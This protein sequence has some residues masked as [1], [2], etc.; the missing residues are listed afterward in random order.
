VQNQAHRKKYQITNPLLFQLHPQMA[1]LFSPFTTPKKSFSLEMNLPKSPKGKSK[2]SSIRDKNNLNK[3]RIQKFIE[4]IKNTN[5]F[6]KKNE[7]IF[8]KYSKSKG[9]NLLNLFGNQNL[10]PNHVIPKKPM[11]NIRKN[12]IA[13]KFTLM[14]KKQYNAHNLNQKQ[15]QLLKD[16][17]YYKITE[18]AKRRQKMQNH[19]SK[20]SNEQERVSMVHFYQ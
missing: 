1:F 12:I 9:T 6:M 10:N 11:I 17:S 3:I 5:N 4:E 13:Q 14:L 18:F 20:Y 7:L 16:Q 15:I 19:F 2:W 8:E